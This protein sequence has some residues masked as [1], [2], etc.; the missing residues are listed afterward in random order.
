MLSLLLQ[1]I[2]VR[3]TANIWCLNYLIIF[4]PQSWLAKFLVHSFVAFT[5][6]STGLGNTFSF[7]SFLFWV[8]SIWNMKCQTCCHCHR[9]IPS[10]PQL[11][12]THSSGLI[13]EYSHVYQGRLSWLCFLETH[14]SFLSLDHWLT[15]LTMPSK[16]CLYIC[17]PLLFISRV[18]WVTV[19][20]AECGV[21]SLLWLLLCWSFVTVLYSEAA[22]C[23]IS[24]C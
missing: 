20:G 23:C 18:L 12:S 5:F 24:C 4:A 3:H 10:L 19:C 13:V 14:H 21:L 9:I 1:K 11:S 22:V 8:I 16:A 6:S 17:E 15:E 2:F 7:S